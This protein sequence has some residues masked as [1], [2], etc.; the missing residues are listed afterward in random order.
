[1]R[2]VPCA[3]VALHVL[4]ATARAQ[5]TAFINGNW[6]DGFAFVHRTMWSVNG[7]LSTAK[8]WEKVDTVDLHNGYAVPA[9]GDAHS[10]MPASVSSFESTEPLFLK[11]GTFYILN[12]N[13][14]AEF[15]NPIRPMLTATDTTIDVLF[16]HAGFTCTG[17]H[18]TKLYQRLVDQKYVAL[19][20]AQL[21]GSAFYTID[22]AADIAR[23]WPAF[24]ATKPDFVK[25]YLLHSE[26]WS[27]GKPDS[28]G[29]G[30]R[31]EFVPELVQRAHAAGLR[32]GAHVESARDFYYAVRSGVDFVMHLPGYHWRKHDTDSTYLID[33]GDA[34]VA[35]RR[36][37]IVVT[38]VGLAEYDLKERLPEIRRVQRENLN[39]LKRSG[40]RLVIG[41][42]GAPGRVMTEVDA[43][44]ATGAFT[45]LE[46]LQMLTVATP[47]AIY[48]GRRIGRI[49]DGYE[50]NFVVAAADPSRDIDALQTLQLRVKRGVILK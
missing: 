32:V 17:G 23:K 45:N 24:L 15:S 39:R 49:A 43:L 6:F 1:M 28:E 31:P 16:A 42:D 11:S 46:L 33:P 21:E 25:L 2:A 34:A 8:Q 38:T 26:A 48:P 27:T 44:R 36:G 20:K 7:T 35:A 40:V 19:T 50:A 22:S 30:L 10:H 12:P 37:I 3:I 41:T 13:D 5:T 14:I 29:S 9:F 18:P 4:T 47:Q